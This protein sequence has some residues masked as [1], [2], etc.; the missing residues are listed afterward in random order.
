MTSIENLMLRYHITYLRTLSME[1]MVVTISSHQ[2]EPCFEVND[3]HVLP[4]GN[5]G[6]NVILNI[7]HS[8]ACL[9]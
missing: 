8:N 4:S 1:I 9:L 6:E 5:R 7:C 2:A 3:S